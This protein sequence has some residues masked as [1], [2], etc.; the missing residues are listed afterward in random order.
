MLLYIVIYSTLS[1]KKVPKINFGFLDVTGKKKGHKF[2][3]LFDNF[4]LINRLD[5]TLSFVY[6]KIN[7][8]TQ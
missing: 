7:S 2:M 3:L 1:V 4:K 5:E 6:V 8:I